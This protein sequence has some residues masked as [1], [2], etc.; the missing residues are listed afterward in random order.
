MRIL[1]LV[2]SIWSSYLSASCLLGFRCP[3]EP[4][5][6]DP[7]PISRKDYTMHYDYRLEW[8]Y[9]IGNVIGTDD[10]PYGFQLTL[11]RTAVLPFQFSQGYMAHVAIT[12]PTVG[13]G[14]FF[15]GRTKIGPINMTFNANPFKAGFADTRTLFFSLTSGVT[16]NREGTYRLQGNAY[17]DINKVNLEVD[18]HVVDIQGTVL[19]GNR[20]YSRKGEEKCSASYYFSQPRLDIDS[21]EIS[22]LRIG[23]KRI[24]LKSGSAWMDHEYSTPSQENNNASWD[25]FNLRLDNNWQLMAFYLRDKKTREVKIVSGALFDEDGKSIPLGKYDFTIEETGGRWLS[26]RTSIIYPTSWRLS[27]HKDDI[28][29]SFD[30]TALIPNQELSFGFPPVWVFPKYWEGATKVKGHFKGKEVTGVGYTELFGYPP[31]IG[32]EME[33]IKQTLLNP[34]AS[35]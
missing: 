8:M 9:Y 7:A 29:F 3:K 21:R 33:A 12:A 20:G 2:L 11:F 25:W 13:D 24:D 4:S 17:D 35:L 10:L 5:P 22:F 14:F 15:G 31:T 27:G 16:G 19:Q 23:D 30:I 26:R 34:A 1:I 28:E 18:V 6:F 32:E